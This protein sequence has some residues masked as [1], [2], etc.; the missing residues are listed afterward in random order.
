MDSINIE[1]LTLYRAQ[2][3]SP[4]T[5]LTGA[6]DSTGTVFYVSDPSVLPSETPFLLTLGFDASASETVLVTSINNGAFTCV[7]GVDGAAAD[8]L[9]GTKVARMFTAKDLN[10]LQSN[11]GTLSDGV[12]DARIAIGLLIAE[13]CHKEADWGVSIANLLLDSEEH[14]EEISVLQT[15]DATQTTNINK[16]LART[17]MVT[18]SVTL[19]N[20]QDFPFND[21]IRTVAIS[22]TRANAN[23]IVDFHVASAIGN[24]GDIV[25]SDKLLNGFKIE[26]TG[27]A[28]S[29]TIN[30]QILGGMA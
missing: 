2:T 1:L 5:E 7:R 30:Y 10:D 13:L 17:D 3:N 6:I 22:P 14:E 8:W 18:G 12:D 27:S 20:T 21:S 4:A 23:Y 19:T 25:V 16:L 28:S 9:A 26:F 15:N 24:V 11:I 29:V